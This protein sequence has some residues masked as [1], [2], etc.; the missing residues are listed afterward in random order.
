[1]GLSIYF[2]LLADKISNDL[3]KVDWD[4]SKL[5]EIQA[6]HGWQSIVNSK[7]WV[8]P[9][10]YTSKKTGETYIVHYQVRRKGVGNFGTYKDKRVAELVRDLL[11]ECDW[12][13][14]RLDWIKDYANYCI[15]EV[16][17]YEGYKNY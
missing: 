14:N 9:K 6:K 4:K 13:K 11:V 2:L 12:D 5:K 7:R 10:E 17:K 3:Q 16:D 8:Y 15:S 1:M